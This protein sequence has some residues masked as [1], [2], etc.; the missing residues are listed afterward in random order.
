MFKTIKKH[1]RH[2][3]LRQNGIVVDRDLPTATYGRPPAMWTVYPHL[4]QRGSLVYSFGVGNNIAW[5]LEMIASHHVELHAFDPTPRSLNWIKTQSLPEEFHLHP[6]G[7]SNQDGLMSFF[8]PTDDHKVNFSSYESISPTN[9]TVQCPVKRFETI[10][11][12]LGHTSVDVLKMDIEG[13]EMVAL[14]DILSGET[15]IG[16]LLIEFHY[17]YPSISFERFAEA[18]TNIRNAGFLIFHISER[19]YEFSFVHESRL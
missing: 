1:L 13:A 14:P 12:E 2:L 15:E 6:V 17:L 9:G 8:V 4:I 16:H 10:V 5:D 11:S 7:L 18:V 3:R 19:G